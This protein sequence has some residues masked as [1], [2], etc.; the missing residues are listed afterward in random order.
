M[1][2]KKL[3]FFL[4]LTLISSC[5][6]DNKTGI[7][8][9][10]KEEKERI[11]EIEKKQR[12]V[13]DTYKVYSSDQTYAKEI[14][15]TEKISL[16]K[17]KNNSSWIMSDLNSQ[18]FLGNIYISG[19]E[20][21][22]LKKK[23]GKNKFDESNASSSFLII[24]N[25][26]I[27]SDD[28]GTVYKV[29]NSGKVIWKKNIYTKAYKRIRKN[30]V[31]S[32]YDNN[33]YIADN[34]GFIY[35]INLDTGKLFWIKNHGVPLK[36]NIKIFDRK[37]YIID[38]DNKI[39]SL[40]IK[41]G[42]KV[43]EF[44]SLSSFIK[45]QN[46]LSLALS[47]EGDLIFINSAADLYKFDS[48]NG[49]IYWSSNTTKSLLAD[50]TDFF[51]S[52]DITLTNKEV[53]F[54]A[55]SLFFSYD[56]MKGSINWESEV[57][58]VGAPIIDG[59][60]IFFVTENGYFVIMKKGTG[61]II[62]STNILNILKK[63]KKRKTKISGFVMGSGKIYSFTKNGYLIV[64]SAVSGKTEQFKKIGDE[65]NSKPIICDGKLYILTQNSKIIVF[66]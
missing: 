17:P 66:N 2:K 38:Q 31:F 20:N 16:S 3:F 57:S 21:I 22:F 65:I 61:K 62:S 5:S 24:K 44:L 4:L 59:E 19:I 6:F 18:N 33:I 11:S 46:L 41:D 26:I 25:S 45:S 63:E 10:G 14:I 12:E 7:W 56:L 35:S 48:Q 51:L 37:I 39:L 47:K 42:S 52:S 9:G 23:I 30:L 55:N 8:G 15:L 32:I 13:I 29:S 60:N 49:R 28:V 64:S 40:N 53:I 1:I 34:I 36:S 58:S 43:W 27:L 50:A 54:S